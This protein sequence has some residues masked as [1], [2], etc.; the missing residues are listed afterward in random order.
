[1]PPPFADGHFEKRSRAGP[2]PQC[3][4]DT[5]LRASSAT[6]HR[7]RSRSCVVCSMR[8]SSAAHGGVRSGEACPCHRRHSEPIAVV[9]RQQVPAGQA[10]G[11]VDPVLLAVDGAE[12]NGMRTPRRRHRLEHLAIVEGAERGQLDRD[13]RL[14]SMT[15]STGWCP[16]NRRSDWQGPE[17]AD[18]ACSRGSHRSRHSG[19]CAAA[20]SV[21]ARAFAS[22][23]SSPT[24]MIVAARQSAIVPAGRRHGFRNSGL[25]ELHIHAILAAAV[26]EAMPDGATEMTRRWGPR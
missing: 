23:E 1:M 21:R 16:C 18:A 7:R 22:G 25:T 8:F 24:R 10:G 4:R 14:A 19:C 12:Q 3:R 5:D 17:P 15:A 2:W 20:S 6:S 11:G 9:A 26:F 13:A